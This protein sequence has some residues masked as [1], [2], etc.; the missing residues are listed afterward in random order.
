[1]SAPVPSGSI[2][3]IVSLNGLTGAT[4]PSGGPTGA[5]GLQ[6]VQGIQG[7]QGNVGTTGATGLQGIQGIEGATG[8]QG[9]T[10]A[11]GQL[12]F[13]TV[14]DLSGNIAVDFIGIPSWAKKIHIMFSYASLNGNSDILMFIGSGSFT[15]SGYSSTA[16]VIGTSTVST[17]ITTEGFLLTNNLTSPLNASGFA[18]LINI[19]ANIWVISS[20]MTRHST[21]ATWV[22]AGVSPSLS[23]ALDRIRIISSNSSDVFD[24]GQVNIAYE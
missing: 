7:P 4:G 23:G 24:I 17:G 6:G 19:S 10:G 11:A 13:T 9:A 16:S 21:P 14:K 15:T 8:P 18:T 12:T 1:M 2:I 5:T 20:N 22:A 3:V